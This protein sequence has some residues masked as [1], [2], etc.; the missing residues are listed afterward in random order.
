M[1]G[2]CGMWRVGV[3]LTTSYNFFK[4]VFIP[5]D[6]FK[7]LRDYLTKKKCALSVG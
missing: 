5:V 2:A 3:F 7:G 4:T 6:A 1:S